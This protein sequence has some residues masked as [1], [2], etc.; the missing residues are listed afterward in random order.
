MKPMLFNKSA[1]RILA[2][3][4]LLALTP[5]CAVAADASDT[6][7][8]LTKAQL[9]RA[10]HDYIASHPELLMNTVNDFLRKQQEQKL[11]DAV[12]TNR[13]ELY[14]N[15][16]SPFRAWPISGAKRLK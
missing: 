15:D 5:V 4:S 13:N 3:L 7:L 11:S 12:K 6:P 16:N 9:D 2:L 1:L 8:T 14:K 10:M